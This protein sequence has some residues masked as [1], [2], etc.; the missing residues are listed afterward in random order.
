MYH[1]NCAGRGGGGGFLYRL[2]LI[3]H[4]NSVDKFNDNFQSTN[5]VS[6][7]FSRNIPT[8]LV[9]PYHLGHTNQVQW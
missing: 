1:D 8:F 9:H 6:S 5:I 2:R 3:D 7:R 4:I